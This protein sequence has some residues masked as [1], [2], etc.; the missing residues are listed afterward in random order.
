MPSPVALLFL[1]V[2]V[3]EIAPTVLAE[4]REPETPVRDFQGTVKMQ[5]AFRGME[6][7]SAD[8]EETD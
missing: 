8:G 3:F 7:W 2:A 6:R 5:D 1:F 4:E